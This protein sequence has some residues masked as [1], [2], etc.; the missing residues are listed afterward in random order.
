[1]NTLLND[2][3]WIGVDLDA[4]LAQY[5]E[6]RGIDHIG[7]PIEAMQTR[8]KQWLS[9]GKHVRILTARVGPQ[10]HDVPH[11]IKEITHHIEQWC[12]QHLGQVLPVTCA[13]DYNM[14]AFYDDRCIQVIPNTGRILEDEQ[15]D[16]NAWNFRLREALRHYAH[17]DYLTTEQQLLADTA[18]ASNPAPVILLEQHAS[19]IAELNQRLIDRTTGFMQQ[20]QQQ[21]LELNS[22][23]T[24]L[25]QEKE[26]LS[27]FT[28]VY[29]LT[30]NDQLVPS[31]IL[32]LAL[33]QRDTAHAGLDK[34][35]A[36]LRT[37]LAYITTLKQRLNSDAA[38][39]DTTATDL[40]WDV[41]KTSETLNFEPETLNSLPLNSSNPSTSS[42]D[43]ATSAPTPP[44]PLSQT[45]CPPE[46]T[47]PPGPPSSTDQPPPAAATA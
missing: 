46:P 42:P 3:P 22:A 15:W 12:L 1:M 43:P 25:R 24:E 2:Q 32:A 29:N 41:L 35:Q 20:L 26:I 36:A 18:L 39:A 17:A 4:T 31:H 7:P 14:G 5:D 33:R 34:A 45:P 8:V 16:T 10:R 11:T 27:A 38:D 23:R 13:K 21:A 19:E 28:E 30:P 37:A 40:I 6:W 44:G 47:T 9:E